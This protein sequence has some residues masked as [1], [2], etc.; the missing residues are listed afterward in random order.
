MSHID[1]GGLKGRLFSPSN[2]A[3]G[4]TTS[5]NSSVIFIP[6]EGSSVKQKGRT[7][8]TNTVHSLLMVLYFRDELGKAAKEEENEVGI[9]GE[10]KMGSHGC[11]K[12]IQTG[13]LNLSKSTKNLFYRSG[14]LLIEYGRVKYHPALTRHRLRKIIFSKDPQDLQIREKEL[15]TSGILR[16]CLHAFQIPLGEDLCE[17]EA[18]ESMNRKK[19]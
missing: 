10:Y 8:M 11:M 19:V 1:E 17:W 4:K 18:R 3:G 16:K 15:G 2:I 7:R 9:M 5:S 13:D 12:A 6:T 14:K